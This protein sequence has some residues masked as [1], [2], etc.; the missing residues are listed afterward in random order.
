MPSNTIPMIHWNAKMIELDDGMAA[1]MSPI[2]PPGD[3]APRGFRPGESLE[4]S[5][6]I[7]RLP[8]LLR[9]FDVY[10]TRV[11]GKLC[12]FFNEKGMGF[13]RPWMR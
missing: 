10:L 6:Q 13:E 2:A 4:W 5:I 12:G 7:E 8:V 9:H 11:E 3:S 1:G